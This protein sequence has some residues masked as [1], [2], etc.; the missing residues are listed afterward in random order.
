MHPYL[1]EEPLGTGHLGCLVLQQERSVL[2]GSAASSPPPSLGSPPSSA[3]V[4]LWL[5]SLFLPVEWTKS[6][7]NC[8]FPPEV[9]TV[10]CTFKF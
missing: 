2:L 7:S 4:S 5:S 3:Q 10:F 8:D 6:G 9:F 1:G